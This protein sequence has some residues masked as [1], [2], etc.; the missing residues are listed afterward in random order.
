MRVIRG[1]IRN[2]KEETNLCLYRRKGEEERGRERER[3]T[4]E[5]ER[6]A[7]GGMGLRSVAARRN[8]SMCRAGKLTVEL[9]FMVCL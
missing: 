2:I 4:R 6:K 3:G 7:G 8:K 1:F 9:V 5:R